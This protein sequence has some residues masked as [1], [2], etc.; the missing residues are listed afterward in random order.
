MPVVSNHHI[1]S[2]HQRVGTMAAGSMRIRPDS[3][4]V[5]HPGAFSKRGSDVSVEPKRS[6]GSLIASIH[7]SEIQAQKMKLLSEKRDIS[8]KDDTSTDDDDEKGKSALRWNITTYQNGRLEAQEP[9]HSHKSLRSSPNRQ[10]PSSATSP[11]H[12]G[13][14]AYIR[15]HTPPPPSLSGSSVRMSPKKSQSPNQKKKSGWNS[16]IFVDIWNNSP[17]ALQRSPNI[18][19]SSPS[20]INSSPGKTSKVASPD[21]AV[22]S[23]ASSSDKV[24]TSRRSSLGEFSSLR[25]M[26]EY[27]YQLQTELTQYKESIKASDSALAELQSRFESREGARKE[28]ERQ[29]KLCTQILLRNTNALTEISEDTI[30]LKVMGSPDTQADGTELSLEVA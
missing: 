5:A 9:A 17:N 15:L 12:N 16:P 2:A 24:L 3:A 11:S 7:D 29:L 14:P 26:D 13:S 1:I 8:K 25:K 27:V 22:S 30:N 28:I 23:K 21:S 20:R 4:R 6:V 10:S 18:Y 19:T